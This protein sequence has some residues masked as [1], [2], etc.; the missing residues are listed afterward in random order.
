MKTC[1]I[2][3]AALGNPKSFNPNKNDLIIAADAGYLKLKKMGIVPQL[4]VGDF[5]SLKENPEADEIIKHPSKKD[6]TDTLLAIKIGLERGYKNFCLYGCAG[7]R[8]DHTIANLQALGFIAQNSGRG[9]L[10]GED[11]VATAIL[12]ESLEFERTHKG[13]IS[14]F[15]SDSECIVSIKGLLYELENK[16]LTPHFPLGVSNEFVGKKATVTA[17]RGTVTVVWEGN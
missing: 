15:A 10:Y 6:D 9:Y 3:S 17:H 13:N 5:D 11:F 12:N 1:Y 2:F 8:I 4:V 14:V 16:K 7:G